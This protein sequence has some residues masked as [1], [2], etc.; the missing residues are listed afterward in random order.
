MKFEL[1]IHPNPT[2]PTGSATRTSEPARDS[3]IQCQRCSSVERKTY[4]THSAES[5]YDNFEIA[6]RAPFEVFPRQGGTFF[7]LLFSTRQSGQ[8]RI[9][10]SELVESYAGGYNTL[11]H[12]TL[13]SARPHLPA[14]MIETGE[15]AAAA[16]RKGDGKESPHPDSR[17]GNP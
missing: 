11:C 3:R 12:R 9:S 16:R 15:E 17:R 10:S 1:S 7:T 6:Y 2:H 8:E 13:D 14:P 5:E 4:V